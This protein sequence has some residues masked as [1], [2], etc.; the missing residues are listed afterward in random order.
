VGAG[1]ALVDPKAIA[2]RRFDVIR[3]YAAQFVQAVRD[4]RLGVSVKS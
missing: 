2:E 4:A 1:T 3:D